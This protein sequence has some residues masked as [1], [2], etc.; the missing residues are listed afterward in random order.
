MDK[1]LYV[2]ESNMKGEHQLAT[3]SKYYFTSDWKNMISKLK[4]IKSFKINNQFIVLVHI[5]SIYNKNMLHKII[6]R[7]IELGKKYN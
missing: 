1:K 7:L 2:S 6:T 4:Y 3:S 5:P